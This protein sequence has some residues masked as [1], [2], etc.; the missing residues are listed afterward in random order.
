MCFKQW[1][2]REFLVVEK[3]AGTNIHGQF[4][5]VHGVNA[6]DEGT[7]HRWA[8]INAGSEKGQVDLSDTAGFWEGEG[9]ILVEIIIR[10][11]TINS[12]L[13]TSTV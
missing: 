3:E 11:Q 12:D 9:V 5:N 10:G 7:V 1:A 13:Y 2:V 6:V 8:S 4:T